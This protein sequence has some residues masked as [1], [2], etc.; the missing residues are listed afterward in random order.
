MIHDIRLAVRALLNNPG[1]A[2]AAVVTLALGIGANT[3]IFTI[4]NAAL[5][6][7]LPLPHPER[8]LSIRE[9]TRE[10]P[11]GST[12]VADLRDYR[13]QST[14][15]ES[16]EGYMGTSLNL[17][18]RDR[19]ER[20]AAAGVTPGYLAMMGARALLGR[21]FA[22]DEDEA[23]KNRAIVLREDVW[24]A[25]FGADPGIIGSEIGVD[26]ERFTVIGVLPTRFRFPFSN[27]QAWVPFT[28]TAAQLSRGNHI[29]QIT[30][31]LRDGAA[32][33]QARAQMQ[34]ILGRLAA[35]YP[36]DDAGR[37]IT[38]R[39]LHEDLVRHVRTELFILLGAVGFVFLIACANVANLLLARAASRGRE[40]AIRRAL[41]AGRWRLL[42]ASAIEAVLLAAAG[43]L[44]GLLLAFWGVDWLLSFR[45]MPAV[46]DVAPDTAVLS[47]TI[48]LSLGSALLLSLVGALQSWRGD[49]RS[50][51]NEGGR[52]A[53]GAPATA[54]TRRVL[55][56]AE[57]AA[58][59]ILLAGAGL[60]IESFWALYRIDPGFRPEGVLTMRL[61]LPAAKYDNS[62]RAEN[63]YSAVLDKVSRLPGVVSAGFVSALPLAE[64][65]SNGG[66]EIEGRPAPPGPSALIAE[67]REASP[68][69]F[70]AL[71]IP[72]LAGR[73]FSS[74]DTAGSPKVAVVNQALAKAYFPNENPIGHRIRNGTPDW[75]SIVGVVGDVKESRL[76]ERAMPMVT[77]PF[78]QNV[79]LPRLLAMSLVVR[80]TAE[81]LPLAA[82]VR[83]QIASIDPG[84]PVFAIETMQQVV[85]DSIAGDRSGMWI[86][87]TF[88]ALAALLAALGI[89]GVISY[90]AR[91]RRQEMGIRM[92][93]GAGGAEVFRIVLWQ[94]LQMA[95]VGIAIGMLGAL[96]LT[97]VMAGHIYVSAT[98][99]VA[100]AAVP[101]F[102]ALLAV[103]ATVVPAVTAAR[104][105]PI[106]ALRYE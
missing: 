105:C 85:L 32:I 106:E 103:A 17:I 81:P 44:G 5:L 15:F 8:L 13:K 57:V 39:P 12:S 31:R 28:P 14:A 3:A 50:A 83:K 78:T 89:Y 84:Q 53:S 62:R 100:F 99:P 79:Y 7:P 54:R 40:F 27:A 9:G 16:I 24:R 46:D 22:A 94:G 67:R 69:Y 74:S 75:V 95:A 104:A 56:I 11:Y 82:A 37:R 42:R 35:Q 25:D 88:A 29:L 102:L 90:L 26:S 87:G 58:S 21:T 60:L 93:L 101:A 65:G 92:A 18:S 33:E 66:I 47:Y 51:L 20:V 97:R 2:L 23:G 72:L 1:F 80:T 77:I 96:A 68:D 59:T 49:V 19:P 71:R 70:R 4:V 91:Q 76:A 45:G 34:S 43:A 73:M 64:S 30:G 52:T 41:G 63:F 38:L 55:V 61:S 86:M 36:E 6:R 98:D 48:A 10:V